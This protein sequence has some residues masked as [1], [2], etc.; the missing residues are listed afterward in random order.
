[1]CCANKKKKKVLN[2]PCGK[3][4]KKKKKNKK[5]KALCLYI[6]TLSGNTYPLVKI[7]KTRR[8]HRQCNVM[9]I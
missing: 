6:Y 4:K 2:P 9:Y 5:N 3:K 7:K 1:M 8:R